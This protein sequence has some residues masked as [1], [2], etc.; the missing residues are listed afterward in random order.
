MGLLDRLQYQTPPESHEGTGIEGGEGSY[1]APAAK[2]QTLL[3]T[4][5]SQVQDRLFERIGPKKIDQINPNSL[6]TQITEIIREIIKEEGLLLTEADQATLIE[7]TTHEMLGLGP[8]EPLLQDNEV[9]D[10]LVNGYSETYVE[11]R[12]KLSRT[13]IRFHDDQHLMQVINRIVSRVGRRIDESSPMVDARL[14]DGSRVNAVIP[15]LAIDG[16]ALCIRR[17]GAFANDIAFLVQRGTLT[18]EMVEFLQAA[19][20]TKLNILISGGTGTGKTTFLNCLSSFIPEDERIITIEDAAELRLQQPH[21]L[22]L[23]TRPPNIE[24]QGEVTQRDLFRNTLRMRPDR[25]IVGEVRGA[26]VLDMLQAMSTGHAGSMAT[27]HANNP[28]DSLSRLEM[29]MLLSGIALPERAMRQYISAALNL[30]VQVN[31]FVDG[32]RKVVKISEDNRNGRR[33]GADAGSVR[34]PDVGFEPDGKSARRVPLYRHQIH[35]RRK[36]GGLGLFCER[37]SERKFQQLKMETLVPFLMV[38]LIITV[39]GVQY[40]ARRREEIAREEALNR[41]IQAFVSPVAKTQAR[42]WP[43]VPQPGPPVV[44]PWDPL[45]NLD[46]WLA[47]G[48]IRMQP[49]NFLVLTMLTGLGMGALVALQFDAKSALLCGLGAAAAPALYVFNKR[50]T[51]LATFSQQLPYVLDFMRSALAAG[52]TLLRGVQMAAENSPEPI[53]TELKLVMDQIQLGSSLSDGLEKMFRRVPEESL[54]FLVAAVRIQAEVGSGISE[55]L[56]RVTDSIRERQRLRQEVRTLTAQARLSG[57]IVAVLPFAL[58]A[59]FAVI[60]PNYVH[61]LFSDP[62][63]KRMLQAAIVLDVIALS[64]IRRMVKVD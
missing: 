10:I 57:T 20:G 3:E 12:G 18:H 32:S 61:P 48:G 8:L 43:R 9:S 35:I 26:E 34:I 56:D 14:S 31:R 47:Q 23:E 50:R 24:G 51:R 28:R 55:I 21:V 42:A 41:R 49:I 59:L 6:L 53:S 22:R 46:H 15:P 52:H 33:R 30:I 17:F 60:R 1:K 25:I 11:R 4:L 13:N 40:I 58:L 44:I 54:G 63:G 36:N 62:L 5:K 37:E 2:P 39:A 29:M 64:I 16:P 38:I 45:H 27:I 7:T 19:V